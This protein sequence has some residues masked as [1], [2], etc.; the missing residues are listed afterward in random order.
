MV[1]TTGGWPNWWGFLTASSAG[2]AVDPSAPPSPPPAVRASAPSKL[3][4]MAG[5]GVATSPPP[6]HTPPPRGP[7]PTPA[8][9]LFEVVADGD[10]GSDGTSSSNPS[11]HWSSAGGGGVAKRARVV[12]PVDVR[13]EA[14][15]P[16]PDEALT[17]MVATVLD[18][19]AATN[20]AVA[21][22]NLPA[23]QEEISAFYSV[24]VP[25]LST[26]SYVARLVTYCKASSAVLLVSLVLLD[27][28]GTG[29]GSDPRLRV[30]GYNL[31]RLL[32]TAV[33]L[34]S[35]SVEDRTFSAAHFAAIGGVD[36]AAEM[37]KLERLML[38]A[39]DW[40]VVVGG[41]MLILYESRLRQRYC[42]LGGDA[43]TSFLTMEA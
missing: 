38:A 20:S 41:E 3:Y 29:P 15:R 18:W 31:H 9:A 22:A 14:G 17:N 35:K 4:A 26:A 25:D 13:G 42:A 5:D 40:R 11:P 23:W 1:A 19:V 12:S 37:A 30:N 6:P 34:A 43:P 10:T 2:R 21:A 7:L 39:L 36:G 27:R 8:V 33:M 32:V 16:S 28:L 24:S